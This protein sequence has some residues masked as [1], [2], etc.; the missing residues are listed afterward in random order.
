M[1]KKLAII[2]STGSIGR[3]TLE[4]I[5]AHPDKLKVVA[6]AA[7]KNNLEEFAE[8]IKKFMPQVVSVPHEQAVSE[9][10]SLLGNIRVEILIGEDGLNA[11]AAAP[12]SD[13]LVTA[14]CWFCWCKTDNKS[15]R[16]R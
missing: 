13:L 7:G 6:L 4:V 15:F 3:Q 12:E 14:I 11:I 1:L 5:T 16:K 2:G 8:Q 10:R 9:L